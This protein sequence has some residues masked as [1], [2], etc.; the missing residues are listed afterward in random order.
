MNRFFS[1]PYYHEISKEQ[2]VSID[3]YTSYIDRKDLTRYYRIGQTNNF[4]N[5]KADKTVKNQAKKKNYTV[6]LSQNWNSLIKSR[7]I[8]ALI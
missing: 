3:R 4:T 1:W 6:F 2:S 7:I 8:N 5:D